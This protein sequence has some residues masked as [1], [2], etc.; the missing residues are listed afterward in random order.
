MESTGCSIKD[1]LF[2]ITKAVL[3][4]VNFP[5]IVSF[6]LFTWCIISVSLFIH[7]VYL[8]II[9]NKCSIHW[10]E[11]FFCALKPACW[12]T[13]SVLLTCLSNLLW[14]FILSSVTLTKW[15]SLMGGILIF[16]DI[17]K[18]VCQAC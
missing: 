6:F 15:L 18:L 14:P 1:F 12:Y 17:V 11:H 4:W 9:L 10:V 16:F 5:I 3:C 2:S 13:K 7:G 8:W